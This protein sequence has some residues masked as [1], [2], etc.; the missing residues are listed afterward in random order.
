MKKP[1]KSSRVPVPLNRM[2]KHLEEQ[3]KFLTR[4]C[5]DFDKGETSEYK[6]IALTIRILTYDGGQSR[7]LLQQLGMK[8][9]PFVSYAGKIDLRN[10][11]VSHPLI[12]MT[13]GES[14]TC[15]LPVLD[16]GP[17]SARQL[18]FENWWK[19]D[20]LCSPDGTVLTRGD[21]VTIVANQD[22]GAHVDP[23]L[24]E[25]FDK[26]ANENLAGWISDTPDGE[27]PLQHIEKMHLRQIGFECLQSIEVAW[28]KRLG[29]RPCLCSSGRKFRYCCGKHANV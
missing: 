19:E 9:I 21:F 20:V 11:L 1:Q 25:R 22:G 3:L 6:R 24:D 13:I 23:R 26:L 5:H 16:K 14:G 28:K 12:M 18:N 4:S 10:L 8:G 17:R 15:F 27:K 29:N 2:E 7:S